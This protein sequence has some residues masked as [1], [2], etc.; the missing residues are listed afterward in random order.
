MMRVVRGGERGMKQDS[1]SPLC[2]EGSSSCGE[3]ASSVVQ[4]AAALHTPVSNE[5]V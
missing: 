4:A 3:G 5:W 2:C 1:P